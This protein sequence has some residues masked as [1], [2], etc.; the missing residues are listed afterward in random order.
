MK[1]DKLLD[2]RAFAKKVIDKYE[3]KIS[4]LKAKPV[5]AVILVDKDP[6]SHLYVR[7]KEQACQRAGIIMEKYFFKK[8]TTSKLLSLIRHLNSSR[9]VKGILVQLPLPR[10]IDKAKVLREIIPEK[11]VDFL[12]PNTLGQIL[13]DDEAGPCTPK[14]I[15]K[16]LYEYKIKVAGK[17]VCIIN[18]SDL[19]G[20]PLALML[21]KRNATVTVCHTKTKNLYDYTKKADIII[22][23]TGNPGLVKGRHV[24]RGVVAIDIGIKKIDEKIYG[25]ID[26]KSVSKKASFIT[27][28]P[29]GVGPVTIAMLVENMFEASKK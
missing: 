25:D 19:V 1:T 9:K 12:N 26:F 13:Y 11:D 28:V 10:G 21:M 22:S 8:T 2:G 15:V 29:G 23:A 24:K 20:R 6:A 17:N 7:L 5:L 3:R 4:K 16:L 27:P 18:N 14:G